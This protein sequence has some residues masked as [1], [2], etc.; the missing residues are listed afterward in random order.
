MKAKRYLF[1][2]AIL[3]SSFCFGIFAAHKYQPH[4]P[5]V[6]LEEISAKSEYFDGK[7]VEIITYAQLDRFDQKDF[8]IGEPL[9]KR[10]SLTFLRLEEN[11]LNLDSL[12]ETLSENYSVNQ[13]K[14][15]KVKVRGKVYDNCNKG[16]TC[17]VG[18]TIDFITESVE[19]IDQ[20]EDYTVPEKF[21]LTD[22]DLIPK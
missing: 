11:S 17:C 7:Y 18:N 13:Y 21:Q 10:E 2:L 1:Y 8:T 4:Y 9:E 14:R 6:S 3:I 19:Q 5:L 22:S 12:K 16:V 20:I 15:V